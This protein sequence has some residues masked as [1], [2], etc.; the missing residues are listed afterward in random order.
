MSL[1]G[2]TD[3]ALKEKYFDAVRS[4]NVSEVEEYLIQG[5]PIDEFQVGGGGYGRTA[6][7]FAAE[8]NY[9][10]MFY[11]L[12]KY[13][14]NITLLDGDGDDA[15]TK[16]IDNDNYEIAKVLYELE[17]PTAE[18]VRRTQIQ[19]FDDNGQFLIVPKKDFD[20]GDDD[21]DD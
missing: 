2:S 19:L 16:A 15:L 14:P 10:E 6:L 4:N 12:M 20:G 7:H 1:H 13:N 3:K 21:D 18:E 5:V 17:P 11:M 9:K 8:F